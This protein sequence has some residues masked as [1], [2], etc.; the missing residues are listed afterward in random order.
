MNKNKTLISYI[1]SHFSMH[2]ARIIIMI[3]IILALIK[4]GSVRQ[5]K[6]AQGARIQTKTSSI[7]RRIQRFFEQQFLHPYKASKLIFSM[8]S[9]DEKITFTL[10]RTNWK[11]GIIDINFLVIC[12]IYKNYSIPLCWMLL[13]HQGNS[14]TKCRI[15]LI[16]MLLS[17]VPASRIKSLLA[18]REFIGKEWFQYL[19]VSGIPFCIRIKENMLIQDT[20]HGGQIKLNKLFRHLLFGQSREVHQIISGTPLRICATRIATGE[21]LILAISG[22]DNLLD[23]FNLYSLRWTIETMFKSF[24]SSGFNFEDTHQHNFERLYKLMILLTIAYA[25]AIR[26]GE[27]KNNLQPIKIKIN[28]RFE[29]SF[30]SY[31]FRTIQTILLKGTQLQ[32]K[33]LLLLTKITLNDA[34]FPELYEITVV[35]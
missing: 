1:S 14:D 3:E 20:H 18:D 32:K 21:F 26:I 9:W 6:L 12:G 29:F 16:E 8:F 27:I 17:I 23:P 4:V 34:I 5:H 28:Q 31:G 30:F 15:D 24:K 7:T 35:Y 33:L 2:P 19:Q 22:D 11:F 13:A 25:W 10:D